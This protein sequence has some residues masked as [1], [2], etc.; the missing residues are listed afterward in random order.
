MFEGFEG[1]WPCFLFI[2]TGFEQTFKWFQDAVYDAVAKSDN[3]FMR[4]S[5]LKIKWKMEQSDPNESPPGCKLIIWIKQNGLVI[6]D[7]TEK[8]SII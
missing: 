8:V 7:Y 5:C 6:N 1:S 2:P 4:S 3:K